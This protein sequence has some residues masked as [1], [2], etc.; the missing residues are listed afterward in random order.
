MADD[1]DVQRNK[2][3]EYPLHMTWMRAQGLDNQLKRDK[4]LS[5]AKALE[6]SNYKATITMWPTC[7]LSRA[8]REHRAEHYRVTRH[9]QK[10]VSC[11]NKKNPSL[12]QYR[13][14]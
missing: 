8:G 13:G 7:S 4:E 2:G 14:R 10:V 3:A 1:A 12:A 6:L 9:G 11:A 5:L